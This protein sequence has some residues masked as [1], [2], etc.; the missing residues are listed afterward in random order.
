MTERQLISD[1]EVREQARTAEET[2]QNGL[3]IWNDT[4][5]ITT[6]LTFDMLDQWIQCSQKL[7]ESYQQLYQQGFNTWMHYL[8]QVNDS[9]D[10]AMSRSGDRRR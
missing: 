3:H 4:V 2:M 8:Q 1:T 6:D 7:V 9:V 5:R 10:R